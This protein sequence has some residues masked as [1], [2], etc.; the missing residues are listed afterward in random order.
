[1][2]QPRLW[3]LMCAAV[4]IFGKY[5]DSTCPW[6]TVQIG[7]F[8]ACERAA[9]FMGLSPPNYF[10][11]TAYYS[12]D[13]LSDL[14]CSTDNLGEAYY[15][16]FTTHPDVRL[17]CAVGMSSSHSRAPCRAAWYTQRTRSMPVDAP[18]LQSTHSRVP[19]IR[20]LRRCTMRH[21]P[22]LSRARAVR[23]QDH[24]PLGGIL[25]HCQN[26]SKAAACLFCAVHNGN[27]ISDSY[28]PP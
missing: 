6:N 26:R 21:R 22:V 10:N 18:A 7:S 14:V 11:Y 25:R 2:P 27:R 13:R 16:S 24:A 9:I 4:Y 28:R 3:C 1:V 19:R 17:L 5:G 20:D 12:Q 15:Q 23:L 8:E